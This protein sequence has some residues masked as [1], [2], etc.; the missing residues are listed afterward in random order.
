MFW[1]KSLDTLLCPVPNHGHLKYLTREQIA[2]LKLK[3]LQFDEKVLLVRNEY[4]VACKTIWSDKEAYFR[5]GGVVVT[6]QPGAGTYLCLI[7]ISFTNI[8]DI[9]VKHAF[10]TICCFIC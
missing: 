7:I 2:E 1:A 4:K 8:H 5:K 10:Y 9:Q 6:G 3:H